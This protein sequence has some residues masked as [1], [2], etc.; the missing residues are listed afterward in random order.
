MLNKKS[1]LLLNSS[2]RISINWNLLPPLYRNPLFF[3]FNLIW[4]RYW[5]LDCSNLSKDIY[6]IK[7]KLA[8]YWWQVLLVIVNIS[9]ILSHKIPNYTITNAIY[10]DGWSTLVWFRNVFKQNFD[11]RLVSFKWMVI[12]SKIENV[13]PLNSLKLQPIQSL[14]AV[15]FSSTSSHQPDTYIHKF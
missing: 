1:V 8:A 4:N 10:F 2:R 11:D 13:W 6:Y 9:G 5:L 7:I 15:V 3:I 14:E 12:F